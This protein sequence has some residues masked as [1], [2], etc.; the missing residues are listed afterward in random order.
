MPGIY[1]TAGSTTTETTPVAGANTATG[2]SPGTD[3]VKAEPQVTKAAAKEPLPNASLT[4]DYKGMFIADKKP[5][6]NA[7]VNLLTEKGKVYKTT[8][9]DKNGR[10]SFV[11][12]PADKK[13]TVGLNEKETKKYKKVKL[14]DSASEIYGAIDG[15]FEDNST[16]IADDINAMIDYF[17]DN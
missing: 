7:T 9:T 6:A 17:F 14:L 8:K 5:F 4:K 12:I 2:N 13:L 15:Y 10:F 1:P 11:G 16:I 3:S